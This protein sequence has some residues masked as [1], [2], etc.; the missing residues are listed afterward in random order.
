MEQEN[1]GPK[2]AVGV[3]IFKEGKV[4]IGKRRETASH[5][6]S[7]YC[8]PG[9][10]MEANESFEECA[11]RETL[12]ESGIEIK[13]LKF[14]C[15]ANID[16]FKNHQVVLIGMMADWGSKEPQSFPD[17]NIG[18]W[19]WCDLDKLPSPLFYPTEIVIKSYKTGK[20]YFDLN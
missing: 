4:L 6:S 16:K 11:K 12:E 14:L 8:F 3:I 15:V 20:N 7:E 9:G 17:E 5:G 2:T 1:K 19:R 13:N 10:H 18:D